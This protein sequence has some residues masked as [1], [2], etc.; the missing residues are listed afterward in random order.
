M[1]RR[2]PLEA[3][4]LRVITGI[5]NTLPK[6]TPMPLDDLTIRNAKPR[7][8]PF[9]LF[10]EKGCFLLVNPNASKLWRLKYPFAGK[11]KLLALGAY[12]EVSLK[13]ARAKRDEARLAIRDG[14]DP[15]GERKAAKRRQVTEAQNAFRTIA[16]E[17]IHK[18]GRRW[19][20]R[21]R[22]NAIRRLEANS[23]RRLKSFRLDKSSRLNCSK[24]FA[25][26][27]RVTLT[28][29][30]TGSALY[31][32]QI[33][34][35]GIACGVC[36]RDP[37]ADLR[38]ALTPAKS[39]HMRTIPLEGLPDL[40][41]E[42]DACEEAPACRDRQTR[43]ALM[44]IALTFVRTG[45]LRK[46]LWS[47]VDWQEKLWMLVVEVMKMRRPH[48]VPLAPQTIAVLRELRE[49][50]GASKYLFPGEGKKGIMSE[51]TSSMRLCARYRGRMSGHV[52]RNLASTILNE[53]GF[54]KMDRAPLAHV[55]ENESRRAYDHAKWLDQRA[56]MMRWYADYLDELRKG[57]FV[58][59]T[60][61]HHRSLGSW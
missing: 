53:A 16:L 55:E 2:R 49:I 38:G 32:G 39:S 61:L 6:Y 51:N 26:S 56:G 33:F 3:A 43:L 9:K 58:S 10:D 52:F 12:P 44:L 18:M 23:S 19:G 22:A 46:G 28:K 42:I 54:T 29:W 8:K 11:E 13:T 50:T 24:S 17:F 41:R 31:G 5:E 59:G 4:S 20:E 60:C 15:C 7:E 34:R 57:I 36:S 25:G 14:R 30:R 27:R 47:Q 48:I 40:L 21:H 1:F 45:E 37:A 35:Y